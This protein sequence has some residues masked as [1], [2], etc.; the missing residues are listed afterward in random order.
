M[1]IITPASMTMGIRCYENDEDDKEQ[2]NERGDMN[3]RRYKVQQKRE[4]T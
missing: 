3:I 1:N 4:D 2:E